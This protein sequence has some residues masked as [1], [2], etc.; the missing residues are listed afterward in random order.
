MRRTTIA[1]ILVAFACVGSPW[2]EAQSSSTPTLA[3]AIGMYVF[4]TKGQSANQ[5]SQDEAACYQWA[6]K[7]TGS[8]PF[9]LQKQSQALQQQQAA[10]S[11]AA[12]APPP[13]SGA[14][15]A[16]GGA[17]A[18][19]LFGAIGGSAGTGAAVGA[20]TG[21]VAGRLRGRHQ[22]A[23]A[24]DAAEKTASAQRATQQQIDNFK[25]AFSACLEGKHYIAK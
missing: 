22:Q 13:G 14:R 24:A 23:Q 7:Q 12:A 9:Q 11:Q 21:F 2:V 17:A 3:S 18:G 20:A 1:V 8:D 19:A 16:A 25:K 5:Q 4:P 6:V 15:G 10:A